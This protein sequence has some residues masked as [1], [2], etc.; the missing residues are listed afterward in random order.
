MKKTNKMMRK[1]LA[2]LLFF[3]ML[4]SCAAAFA[5]EE[6]TPFDLKTYE[7]NTEYFTI[8]VNTEDDLAF[9]ETT[10]DAEALA[11]T[12][13]YDSEYYYSHIYN[14]IIVI[15]Y[16]KEGERIPV[17]RTW[18]CCR[19]DVPHNIASVTFEIGG[20]AYT[21]T[22][23]SDPDWNEQKENGY[24]ENLLI[25]YGYNNWDFFAAVASN[26]L[27][28]ILDE[29]GNT[30]APEMKMIL[31]GDEDI[32]AMVPENYWGDFSFLIAP[33]IA[34]SGSWLMHLADNDGTP[35]EIA[36]LAPAAE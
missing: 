1:G 6:V 35:C 9:V 14:D 20:K 16:S 13:K 32:E 7:E 8:D 18:I 2:L 29:E 12:H 26:A 10:F 5:E 17:F 11:F 22:E 24:A 28:Y 3:A 27:S 25:D 34:N 30:P 31:H 33:F 23:V 21:F 36:D 15:D 19:A 4:V